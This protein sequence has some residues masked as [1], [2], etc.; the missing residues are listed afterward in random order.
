MSD[1]KIVKIFLDERSII[2]R[3]AQV[4]HE[5]KVAIYDLI[6]ENFFRPIGDLSGPYNLYL[7]ISENRLIFDVCDYRDEKL[8][9]FTQPLGPFRSVVK[10]YFLICDSYYEAI[11][12]L[13]PSKI[14]AID[15][16]RRSLHNEGAEILQNRLV[17]KVEIDTGTARRLFTLICVL[18]IRV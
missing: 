13:T 5:R 17:D 18:H 8:I 10:D 1:Q 16:G 3:S 14:E 9:K 6:E 4:D 7:S 15:V 12:T 2:S 11:K